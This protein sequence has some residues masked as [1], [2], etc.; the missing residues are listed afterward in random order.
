MKFKKALALISGMLLLASCGGIN[1]GGC[2]D[3]HI[4]RE[5]QPQNLQESTARKRK[6]RAPEPNPGTRH[7]SLSMK[8]LSRQQ[9]SR[10]QL[11]F[12]Y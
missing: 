5:R 9:L 1:D 3:T 10:Q 4:R 11:R 8:Q 7:H 6:R 12:S 2:S